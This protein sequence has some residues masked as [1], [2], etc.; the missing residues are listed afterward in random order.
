MANLTRSI[1]N[2][3]LALALFALA[4]V[5]LI[6]ATY[7]GTRARI[8]A[9]ER[10]FAERALLEILPAAEHDNNLLDTAI[11]IPADLDALG[12][13][14]DGTAYVGFKQGKPHAV[15]LPVNAPDGYN[16]RIQLLVGLFADGR[17]SGVRVIG[18][19]ETPGLGDKIDVKVTDWIYGFNGKSLDN[20]APASWAVKKDGGQ[21]DQFTGAT[22]TPRAVVKAVHKALYYFQAH[23][24]SLFEQGIE[25]LEESNQNG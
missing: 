10:L 3:A 14:K 9:S 25:V 19:R 17:I 7:V 21:F 20:T 15:I 24:D 16:G 5:G 2:N 18:H 1:R 8:A 4:T 12:L 6:S 23:R 22:I 11:R 13:S